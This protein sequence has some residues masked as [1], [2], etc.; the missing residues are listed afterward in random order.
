[1]GIIE[2]REAI[3]D[4]TFR[5][6]GFR[7]SV[8]QILVCPANA[9]IDFVIRCVSNHG[10]EI[11]YPDPGFP[12]YYSSIYYNGMTPVN[13][14][15]KEENGLRMNPEDVRVKITD[16]TRL[17]I[18]NSPNNPTGAVMDEEEVL[19][20]A[21]LAEEKDVY[22]LSDEVYSRILYSKD[23]FSPCVTDECKERTLLLNSLSK[24]HSMSGWRL[25]YVIGPEELIAKLGLLLQTIFSCIPPFIQIGGK[26][27]LLEREQYLP[28]RVALL[29]ERR[30][31]LNEKL[32]NLKGIKCTLQDGAFYAF[33][34]VT[35]TGM[36]GTEYAEKLL[37]KKGVCLLPGD[38]FGEYGKGY[39]RICFASTPLETIK[40]ALDK[41]KEFHNELGL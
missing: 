13:I 26:A 11:I 33:P 19:G 17:I 1:M 29:K 25:G 7:P 18:M 34:N 9:V 30:D 36:T 27:V 32:N 2:F 16:K 14:L 5:Y 12:S 8:N 41:M 38:C 3:A 28:H 35:G 40:E 21:R 22:L 15:V 24:G 31:F 20:M 6:W 4:Y 10:D 23:H 37:E 39:V